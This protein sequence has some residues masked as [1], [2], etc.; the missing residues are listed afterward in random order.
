MR[1]LSYILPFI[2]ILI[3][4][5][6]GA[7]TGS[8]HSSNITHMMTKLVFE[9][10]VIIFAAKMGGILAEKLKMPS[11]LG[12]L[13]AGIV[14]GPYAL[15]VLVLPGF[16]DG[17]FPI[18]TVTALP[19]SPEL[20]GF[21]TIASIILLFA[22]GLET[23]FSMFLKYSVT[24]LVLGIGGVVASFITGALTAVYFLQVPFMAPQALFLGVMSTATSV[25]ITAR[26]LSERRKMDSP[27][28]VSIMAG[29]VIDDILGIIILAIVLGISAAASHG[30]S[31]TGVNW[32]NIGYV[33]A[34]A[35]GVWFFFTFI[36]IVF[37]YKISNFLKMFKSIST[38][39]VMSLGLAFILAGIFE[40]AGLAMIVGAYVMGL[41]LSRTDLSF[42]IHDKLHTIQLF[43][44]PIFFTVM[45][46]L[47]NPK[48]LM[49]REILMFGAVYTV[50]A[51][52][53]KII[54]CGIPAFALKFNSLGA[55][56]IGLGMVPR[57]EVALIIAGIGL[58]YGILD[59]TV[60]GVGIMMTLLTT[61]IAPPLLN[62]SLKSD[63]TGTRKAVEENKQITTTFAAPSSSLTKIL[64]DRILENFHKEGFF[65]N[66]IH[67][68]V[69][70]Y[71]LKK[72]TINITLTVSQFVIEFKTDEADLPFV[73]NVIYETLLNFKTAIT[74]VQSIVDSLDMRNEIVG[75]GRSNKHEVRRHLDP[76]HIIIQLQSKT[77]DEIIRK[78][79]SVFKNSDQINN[80]DD[81]ISTLLEREKVMSTGL[82]DGIAIP[83]AKSEHVKS[84]QLA[85]GLAPEGIDFESLDG[86]PSEIFFL[87]L[88]PLNENSSHL[89]MMS[90]ITS[91]FYEK[92]N[93]KALL[94][95]TST[96]SVLNFFAK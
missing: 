33:A 84:I 2:I 6:A 62:L 1:P 50:G 95:C 63:K 81:I 16:P 35:I 20:Y 23:D 44:V 96:Q 69:N 12:E 39:S 58:S 19:V 45:G 15:G 54:G 67:T 10:G 76:N 72:D 25:G 37:A 26:I 88:S 31:E 13:T 38:F 66:L 83:H 89:Q 46:M 29:A 30:N 92:M 43:L 42:V 28:G 73:K 71:H 94:A 8:E 40:K 4:A 32:T 74:E 85:I 53:A 14:I 41:S 70:N 48:T 80:Q 60:F 91:I 64:E 17:L 24:G 47:V 75:K 57:G 9:I 5:L 59:N 87:I 56:R 55:L 21:A 77:K 86:K 93:R 3:P 27:E 61:L 49:S 68:N 78:L 79:V 7:S 82:A 18:S 65:I 52:L 34:K 22:A 36:G 11:V 90:N 51:V